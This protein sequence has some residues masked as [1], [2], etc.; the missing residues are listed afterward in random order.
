MSYEYAIVIAHV[1]SK[2][3]FNGDMSY[4]CSIVIAHVPGKIA[5][6]CYPY[7]LLNLEKICGYDV[8]SVESTN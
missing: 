7:I 2:I 8:T 3:S 6:T 4:E 5:S 1:P